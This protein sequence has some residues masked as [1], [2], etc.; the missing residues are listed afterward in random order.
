MGCAKKNTYKADYT[1]TAIQYNE[2]AT[3]ILAIERLLG[4][5]VYIDDVMGCLVPSLKSITISPTNYL[6]KDSISG[7]FYP[8]K[9]DIFN[10][11]YEEVK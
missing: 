3:S 1:V 4:E 9:P 11:T 2:T 8:C 10:K 6:V 7:E 5:S